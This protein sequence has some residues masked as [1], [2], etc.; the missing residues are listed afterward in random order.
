M[1][2]RDF[3]RT[4]AALSVASTVPRRLR[5]AD[6]NVPAKPNIILI[7]ADDQGWNALSIQADPDMPGSGSTYYQTPRLAKLAQ[8]GVRFSQA[9]SPAPTC[10]PTR[11][12]IQFGRSPASLKIWG[13]DRIGTGID[14]KAAD[15]MANSLKKARPEY[16]CAHLGKW[17]IAFKP[18]ALG[19]DV[20]TG[21]GANLQSKDPKDPKF[22]FSLTKK[23]NAFMEKQVKA[24]RPFF[25]QISHYADHLRYAAL[26]K[27]IDKY[28]TQHA[29]KATKY[30]NRPLW[31]AMNENLD[32]GIGMVLDKIDELGIRDNTYVIY[33]ADNGYEDKKDF[34]R[35]VHERGYYKAY[36]QRSHKYHVSEGGIRVPF[37][38]R[39]PGIPTNTHSP[40][41]V[42]GTDVFPTVMDILG[43][44]D[45]IP[46]KVEGASLLGH[47]QSG[48]KGPVRRK[49]PFLVFKY[50]KPRAPHDATIVQGDYKLI[51][52]IDT[53]RVFLFN[54]KED[55]GESRN[56]ADEKPELAKRMYNDMTAYFKRFGWDESRISAGKKKSRMK[57]H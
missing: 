43:C 21:S 7:L 18:D 6:P 37:I 53:G 34:G 29:D 42:V 1:N 17:H 49:D 48:G 47:L 4:A 39:G 9:Y 26:P 24:K 27:T 57:K 50:S 5:A 41:P 35:P 23:A 12:A 16:A 28:R 30:Q 36:P 31:A 40:T 19:Y 38:A 25:L 33:T 44:L 3:L 20:D 14:A 11:Y 54:L 13:A 46:Q 2:R 10:A 56:L 52:D 8:E 32:T 22:I 15:S 45:Q 55:I 51:K